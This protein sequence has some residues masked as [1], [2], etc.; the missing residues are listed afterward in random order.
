[1]SCYTYSYSTSPQQ[2]ATLKQALTLKN[3]AEYHKK[4]LD[5]F[6]SKELEWKH[7]FKFLYHN[8]KSNSFWYLNDLFQCKFINA[9]TVLAY[10][11]SKGLLET[12]DQQDI[13]YKP[14]NDYFTIIDVHSFYDFLLSW[15]D[16]RIDYRVSKLPTLVSKIVF[17]NSRLELARI[18]K[19]LQVKK[20]DGN[21]IY[22]S[23]IE[24]LVLDCNVS[25]LT[26]FLE[27]R[28]CQLELKYF[29]QARMLS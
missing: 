3:T 22:K 6:K 8:L 25:N 24:G 17:P 5:F 12:L 7:A 13:R 29:G 27:S 23:E 11:C 14:T 26:R 18:E 2:Q 4:E 15:N 21:V 28:N 19:A 1:M 20:V 10:N 9:K 16:L